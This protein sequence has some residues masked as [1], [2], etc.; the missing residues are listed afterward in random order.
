MTEVTGNPSCLI[1]SHFGLERDTKISLARRHQ[2]VGQGR[3]IG[4]NPQPE[5]RLWA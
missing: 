2:F 1:D 3:R 4:D 5:Y